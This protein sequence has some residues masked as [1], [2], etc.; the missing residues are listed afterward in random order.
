MFL[1]RM[2][3]IKLYISET[4]D[5]AQYELLQEKKCLSKEI[6]TYFI[7]FSRNKENN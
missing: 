4:T 2:L 6:V 1:W 3:A 7:E 5:W